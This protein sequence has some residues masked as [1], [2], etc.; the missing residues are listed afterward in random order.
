MAAAGLGK[1]ARDE[2]EIK[3]PLSG[4]M[5][6][7]KECREKLTKQGLSATD[8]MKKIGEQWKALSEKQKEK[9]EKMAKDDKARFE[10]ESKAAA[11]PAPKAKGKV[12][13][14]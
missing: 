14:V 3:K 2:N 9:Y 11:E 8:I 13:P 12:V 10:K 6:F 5:W 4:Y 1:P 7:G